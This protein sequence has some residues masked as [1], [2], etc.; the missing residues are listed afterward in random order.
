MGSAQFRAINMAASKSGGEGL[1]TT[2]CTMSNDPNHKQSP[3]YNASPS[4]IP[5]LLKGVQ[6]SDV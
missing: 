5:F 4:H 3:L 6:P 2:I 1:V